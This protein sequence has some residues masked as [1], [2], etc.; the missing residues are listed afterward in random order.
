MHIPPWVLKVHALARNLV[1][2]VALLF[3]RHNFVYGLNDSLQFTYDGCKYMVAGG[4]EFS[5]DAAFAT[6]MDAHQL[7]RMNSVNI[8]RKGS[9]DDIESSVYEQAK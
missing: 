7:T 5:R 3:V 1:F 4:D 8:L 9:A 6:W 2:N